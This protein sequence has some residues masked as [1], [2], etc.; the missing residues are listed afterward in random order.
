MG[1]A[2]HEPAIPDADADVTVSHTSCDCHG[3]ESRGA[4][5]VRGDGRRYFPDRMSIQ[6]SAWHGHA[7]YHLLYVVAWAAA[8]LWQGAQIRIGASPPGPGGY[9]GYA[10]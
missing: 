6:L 9:L 10:R 3:G 1:V 8:I 7:G 5:A 4:S 2:H